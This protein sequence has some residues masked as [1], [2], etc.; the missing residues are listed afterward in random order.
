MHRSWNEK[1]IINGSI[2]FYSSE[3]TINTVKINIGGIKE[4]NG[5]DQQ[6]FVFIHLLKNMFF[7]SRI[8]LCCRP[9]SYKPNILAM[10]SWPRCWIDVCISNRFLFIHNMRFTTQDPKYLIKITIILTGGQKASEKNV[11]SIFTYPKGYEMNS[12]S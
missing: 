1:P 12:N 3:G 2:F 9:S 4:M 6:L 8:V 11:C 7:E 10:K 5:I